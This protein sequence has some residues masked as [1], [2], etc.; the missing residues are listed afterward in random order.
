MPDINKFGKLL[1]EMIISLKA[2][3]PLIV[4]ENR[5]QITMDKFLEIGGNN[6]FD[7]AEKLFAAFDGQSLLAAGEARWGKN[8]GQRGYMHSTD[9]RA[10]LVKIR[11]GKEPTWLEIYDSWV[12]GDRNITQA[13]LMNPDDG[14]LSY[15]LIR[16]YGSISRGQREWGSIQAT[17]K[18]SNGRALEGE[19]AKRLV[20]VPVEPDKPPVEPPDP[21][22]PPIDPQPPIV[23]PVTPPIT[24]P[25]PPAPLPVFALT[26]WSLDTVRLMRTWATLGPGRRA[27]L[28]KL[29][30]ELEDQ[31]GK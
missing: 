30:D 16:E 4:S 17:G 25:A 20:P 7:V 13:F 18:L 10:A 21:V 22:K 1:L 15:C 3:R 23:P 28:V 12:S 11:G 24:P 5:P 14:S 29:A 31:L 6:N 2:G 27:R 19:C 9:H 26:P 8:F